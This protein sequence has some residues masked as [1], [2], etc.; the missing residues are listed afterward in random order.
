M[1]YYYKTEH[2]LLKAKHELNEE[3]IGSWIQIT[4]EEY[5]AIKAQR[6]ASRNQTNTSGE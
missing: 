4:E 3:E 6:K 5:L 1:N 2:G